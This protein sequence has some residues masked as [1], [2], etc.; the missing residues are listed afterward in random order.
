MKNTIPPLPS[1]GGYEQA[2]AVSHDLA[3]AKL[4]QADLADVC[5]KSGA[6]PVGADIVRL[7]FL[8]RDYLIDR[9]RGE[10]SPPPDA[11]PAPIADRLI[12][13]HYLV[14]ATGAPPR[15]ELVA[16]KDLPEGNV[17]HPTFYKR[18]VK[19]LLKK[20][21]ASPAKF[22]EAAVKIGGVK[23]QMGDA[24]VTVQALPKV[25]VTWI[26][27]RGDDEFPAEGSVLF[28][29]GISD[30]LPTEDIAVLCQNIA[31]KMCFFA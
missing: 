26:L 21:G 10:V 16:F 12:I 17:Y 8:D 14:T 6:H 18:T 23:A 20:F 1:P 7:R 2:Y 27:W 31:L 19:L 9:L 11:E 24:A 4:R 28:D 3:F 22:A 13:L 30:Y 29:R 25:A 15:G 5:R